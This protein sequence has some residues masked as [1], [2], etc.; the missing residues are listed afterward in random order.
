MI[1]IY[2][3]KQHKFNRKKIKLTIPLPCDSSSSDS[4]L[5][6]ALETAMKK[7]SP[8]LTAALAAAEAAL[9]SADIPVPSNVAIA[10]VQ[11]RPIS[12]NQ[13]SRP[14]PKPSVQ[15]AVSK[16]QSM[17]LDAER[18]CCCAAVFTKKF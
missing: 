12:A 14:L 4:D 5:D 8:G 16:L 3:A 9:A 13:S 2:Q 11:T 18:Y 10:A 1:W 7:S 15:Q 17:Q 6:D